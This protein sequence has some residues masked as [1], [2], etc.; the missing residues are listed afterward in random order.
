MSEDRLHSI[1][2]RLVEVIR[3]ALRAENVRLV[4]SEQG[5]WEEA[6]EAVAD[7]VRNLDLGD[8]IP[9]FALVE[10]VRRAETALARVCEALPKVYAYDST[11][12]EMAEMH[13]AHR[14]ALLLLDAVGVVSAAP[15]TTKEK[16]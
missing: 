7:A 16:P 9:S 3:E 12:A 8:E 1:E 4:G 6:A 5:R 15:Q 11:D 14:A 10:R 2:E 13:E